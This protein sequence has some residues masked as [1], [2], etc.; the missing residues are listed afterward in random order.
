VQS[1]VLV[2]TEEIIVEFI[3]LIFVKWIVVGIM[4]VVLVTIMSSVKRSSS[5]LV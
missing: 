4:Y 3:S 1:E 5:S 2:P